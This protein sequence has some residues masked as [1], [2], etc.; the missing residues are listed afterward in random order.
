MA[1]MAEPIV[2]H[3]DAVVTLQEVAAALRVSTATVKRMDLPT[4]Y[5]GK[6][7]RFLW[8]QVLDVLAERAA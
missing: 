5:A 3:R 2:F 8:G 1:T 7:P 4:I 6:Q